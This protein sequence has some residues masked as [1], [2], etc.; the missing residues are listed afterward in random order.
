MKPPATDVSTLPSTVHDTFILERNYPVSPDRLFAAFADPAKKRHWFVES[1]GNQVDHYEMDFRAGGKEQVRFRF[2]PGSPV[3]GK[4]CINDTTYLDIVPNQ[5][6]VFASV[7][8][9]GGNPIS[10]S[11]VTAEFLPAATGTDLVL[12]HQ[13][14]FFP[15]ADGPE[16]RKGGWQKLL[17]ILT[18]EFPAAA[19]SPTELSAK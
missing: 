12:T 8:N 10:A 2:K 17:E 9:I 11:L 18:A 3:A 19:P 15:G 4:A 6:L 7:M 1:H 13:G 14:A 5:R 16:M